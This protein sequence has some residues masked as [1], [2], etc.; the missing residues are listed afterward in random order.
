M[1]SIDTATRGQVDQPRPG[2]VHHETLQEARPCF[3]S[4]RVL[5]GPLN[6]SSSS[7][8]CTCIKCVLDLSH[9]SHTLVCVCLLLGE[10][11]EAQCFC[12]YDAY[13]S[14][15]GVRHTNKK[16]EDKGMCCR[17]YCTSSGGYS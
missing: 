1:H 15:Y 3:G 6:R 10:K 4:G 13:A 16:M 14:G 11:T 2:E 17:S 12:V 9:L 7:C 5:T 8:T